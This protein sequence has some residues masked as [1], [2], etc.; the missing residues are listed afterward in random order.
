M[1]GV[2]A[3]SAI[4]GDGDRRS[5]QTRALHP[6]KDAEQGHGRVLRKPP[7][8][9]AF[10]KQHSWCAVT[11]GGRPQLDKEGRTS[12]LRRPHGWYL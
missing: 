4:G 7:V 6:E 11:P 2:R 9:V 10:M 1:E 8:T 3:T 12:A 5:V